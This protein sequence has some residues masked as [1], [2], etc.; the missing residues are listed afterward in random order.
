MERATTF[1]KRG[2]K[3]LAVW[4][5]C[6]CATAGCSGSGSGPVGGGLD[7]SR[8]SFSSANEAVCLVVECSLALG[9]QG[10]SE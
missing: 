4:C 1:L 3:H 8:A 7:L 2:S 5:V 10:S 9:S 6:V